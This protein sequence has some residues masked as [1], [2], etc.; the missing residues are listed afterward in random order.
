MAMLRTQILVGIKYV[1]QKGLLSGIVLNFLTLK[2]K[3]CETHATENGYAEN[4]DT[5]G[6]K[7]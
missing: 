5:G 1:F 2:E 6:N 4:L 7:I 3:Q